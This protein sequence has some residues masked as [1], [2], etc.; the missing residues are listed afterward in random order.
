M[1][2]FPCYGRAGVGGVGRVT[3]DSLNALTTEAQVDQ[4]TKGR[5]QAK[6]VTGSQRDPDADPKRTRPKLPLEQTIRSEDRGPQYQQRFR[7]AAG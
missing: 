4:M 1:S 7:A 6:S 2:A 5:M 3:R